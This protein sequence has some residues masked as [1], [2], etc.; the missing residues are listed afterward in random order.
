MSI[1]STFKIQY[2]SALLTSTLDRVAGKP[3]FLY[4]SAPAK[5][6]VKSSF[7]KQTKTKENQWANSGLFL[8]AF[9]IYWKTVR[10]SIFTVCRWPTFSSVHRP[11]RHHTSQHLHNNIA[12]L[13]ARRKYIRCVCSALDGVGDVLEW[14][15]SKNMRPSN[16]SGCKHGGAYLLIEHNMDK[17]RTESLVAFIN[18]DPRKVKD[19]KVLFSLSN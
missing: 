13:W 11:R 18:F 16:E 4:V 17:G 15:S 9:I 10:V 1:Q 14:R 5:E 3:S 2:I 6:K 19:D 8:H 12:I 7:R